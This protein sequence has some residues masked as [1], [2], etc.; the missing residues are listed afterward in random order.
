MFQKFRLDAEAKALSIQGIS[1]GFKLW[2]SKG[3]VAPTWSKTL[4]S[5]MAQDASQF[6]KL[7]P[8]Y[9]VKPKNKTTI[10]N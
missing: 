2:F 1:R 4:M 10:S 7:G 3:L 6:I 9:I 5:I 8:N